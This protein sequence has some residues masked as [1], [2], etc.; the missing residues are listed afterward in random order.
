MNTRSRCEEDVRRSHYRGADSATTLPARHHTRR[1]HNHR[2][3]QASNRDSHGRLA[4]PE[5]PRKV[6]RRTQLLMYCPQVCQLLLTLLSY[7]EWLCTK[8]VRVLCDATSCH[9]SGPQAVPMYRQLY[10][11]GVPIPL[12]AQDTGRRRRRTLRVSHTP[13][14]RDTPGPTKTVTSHGQS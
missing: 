9:S 8:Q 1:G 5:T 7:R 6:C 12:G 2:A 4:C 13:S 10:G 11:F 3:F 14:S